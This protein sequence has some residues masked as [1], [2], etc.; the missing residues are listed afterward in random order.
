MNQIK[1][2]NRIIGDTEPCFIIAEIGINHNGSIDTAKDLIDI[3]ASAKVDAVKFQTF[4]AENLLSNEICIP[5]NVKSLDSY[6]E[7]VK[8]QELPYNCYKELVRYSKSKNLFFISSPF[9]F[10]AVDILVDSGI[11]VFKIAS[12]NINNIPLLRKI[13]STK[14]PVIISTGMSTIDEIGKAIWE[15]TSDSNFQI[16]LLH[17]ISSYPPKMNQINLRAIKNLKIHFGYPVGFSDHSV[18][19]DIASMAVISGAKILEKHITLDKSMAGPDHEISANPEELKLLIERIREFEIAYGDGIKEVMECEQ[20]MRKTLRLSLV[21]S[22]NIE[23]DEVLTDNN[24]CV[25]RPATGIS[26]AMY[27]SVLGRRTK[28]FIARNNV[29]HDEDIK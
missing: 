19:I 16:G 21:A 14:F 10:E 28:K 9:D 29:I 2:N 7:I 5:S 12:H 22:R 25:K 18:G 6:L 13:A 4:K 11:D 15:I 1:L 27:Y 8:Q 17:C 23:A 20:N 3:A 24:L 26:P